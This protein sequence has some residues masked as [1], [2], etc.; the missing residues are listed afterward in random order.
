MRAASG[1]MR[2]D[3]EASL[4]TY[5]RAHTAY[6]H[7]P[8]K[9]L[10]ASRNPRARNFQL[11]RYGFPND[12]STPTSSISSPLLLKRKTAK[13][14]GFADPLP[15]HVCTVHS[16]RPPRL[17][18]APITPEVAVKSRNAWPSFPL[19]REPRPMALS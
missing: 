19:G 7:H 12:V 3:S 14:H 15:K 4:I 18:A 10:Q 17:H 1:C 9:R 13:I 16:T 5:V 11:L 2:F 6:L 8:S